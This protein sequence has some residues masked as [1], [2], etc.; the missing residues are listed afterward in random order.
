VARS[1][2]LAR[3]TDAPPTAHVTPAD[4]QTAEL[5]A[6]EPTVPPGTTPLLPPDELPRHVAIIMDGN[7]RWARI[8]DLP[9]L[10]GHAAGV[11]AIRALLRHAVRRGVPVLTLYAFSRENWARSDEEVTGLFGLLEAAIR[12]ETEE[13]QAQG[14]RIRLLGRLDELPDATRLSIGEALDATAAGE[15]LLLNIAFNYAGRTELV[16]AVR[17][18]VREGHDAEAIDEATIAGAL[19]TAGLPDP[20][21]VIRTGGE[22]RL[23]NFLI[24]QSAYA[25]L[26]TSDT[27]WP[28]F[29]PGDLDGAL[30]EYAS[31]TRRF[32]R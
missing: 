28:D 27:L 6:T 9:E 15:R 20:D 19:Y 17:S 4:P 31:R 5:P 29:G 26:I 18:I 2:H 12:S 16:D 11:E 25:E 30:A 23:S 22:H 21:L 24:W 32:G 7:R 10:D 14:V 3:P 1:A 13:L 8:R